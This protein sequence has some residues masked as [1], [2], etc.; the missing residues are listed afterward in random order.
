MTTH[1]SEYGWVFC[2]VGLC[3][4]QFADT[5]GQTI[6]DCS[7]EEAWHGGEARNA[8]SIASDG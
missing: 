5:V 3:T 4:D 1:L 7:T 6:V 8:S 2:R